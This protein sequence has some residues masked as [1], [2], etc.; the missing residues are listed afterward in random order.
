LNHGDEQRDEVVVEYSDAFKAK[1]VRK[2]LP[3]GAVSAYA[4]EAEVG[5]PR[6]TLSRWLRDARTVGVMDKPTKKWTPAE[7]FRVVIEASRLSSDELGEFLRR[8]GLHEAQLK[9]WRGAVDASLAD[10]PKSKKAKSPEVK[11]IKQ[12]EWELRRKE[13]ALAEAAAL[14]I[15]QKKMRESGLW[16][17]VDNDTT[18]DS[19]P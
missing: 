17:D 8:E 15:L 7:K 2:M 5:I 11:R 13:K 4:L 3:P 1:M 19:E 6:P 14:L 9:E 10:A 16:A 18:E 12:L